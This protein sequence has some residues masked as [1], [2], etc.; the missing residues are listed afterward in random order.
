MFWIHDQMDDQFAVITVKSSLWLIGNNMPKKESKG[1][2]VI[3]W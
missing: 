2:R 1:G 3:S